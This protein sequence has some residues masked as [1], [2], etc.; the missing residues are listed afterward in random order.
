MTDQTHIQAMQLETDLN[1]VEGQNLTHGL[2]DGSQFSTHDCLVGV[3]T[4]WP[5]MQ[6]LLA[7]TTDSCQHT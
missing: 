1:I 4:D 5:Y 2:K 3:V 7:G 6:H